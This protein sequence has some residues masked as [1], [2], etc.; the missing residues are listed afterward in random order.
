MGCLVNQCASRTLPIFF[1]APPARL[2]VNRRL[3]Q[4]GLRPGRLHRPEDRTPAPRLWISLVILGNCTPSIPESKRLR[5]YSAFPST[6]A[7]NPLDFVTAL[8]RGDQGHYTTNR[9]LGQEPSSHFSVT[10]VTF[11]RCPKD[12]TQC[13]LFKQWLIVLNSE[14][15]MVCKH[16]QLP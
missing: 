1:K 11:G 3:F 16:R 2:T 15:N 5:P 13:H 6:T 14:R 9:R 7:V 4:T 10:S 8:N 12:A